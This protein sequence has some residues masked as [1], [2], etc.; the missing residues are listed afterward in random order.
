VALEILGVV[1]FLQVHALEKAVRFFVDALGFEYSPAT[2]LRSGKTS[3][4]LVKGDERAAQSNV[5]KRLVL[6]VLDSKACA[7]ALARLATTRA[8]STST[9]ASA[10]SRA[11]KTTESNSTNSITDRAARLLPLPIGERGE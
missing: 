11:P 10:L 6:R 2:G 9:K 7:I 8:S 1:P 5:N 4:H 3:I